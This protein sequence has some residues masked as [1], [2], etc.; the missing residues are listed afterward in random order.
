M[1]A[2]RA[3]LRAELQLLSRNGE[4]LL[5]IVAIP[6]VLLVFFSLVDVLP[7]GH[8]RPDRLPRA[9]ASWPSP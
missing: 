4:Q 1:K 9:R 7:D 8:R 2:F 3:Q 6:V 5:L